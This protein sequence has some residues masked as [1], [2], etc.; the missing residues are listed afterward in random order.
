MR[1]RRPA[2]FDKAGRRGSSSYGDGRRQPGVD[3]LDELMRFVIHD[4]RL[5]LFRRA[6]RSSVHGMREKNLENSR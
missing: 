6:V 2:A 3:V 4:W 1:M 5:L